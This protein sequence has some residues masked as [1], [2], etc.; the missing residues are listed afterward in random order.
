MHIFYSF[1]FVY[2]QAGEKENRSRKMK[3]EMMFLKLWKTKTKTLPAVVKREC[4]MAGAYFDLE[5]GVGLGDQ[6]QI[7]IK[8]KGKTKQTKTFSGVSFSSNKMRAK[9]KIDKISSLP[10]WKRMKILIW[11]SIKIPNKNHD[12]TK[13][14]R[15]AS[16]RLLLSECLIPI[17]HIQVSGGKSSA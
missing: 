4:Q 13:S 6:I 16:Q 10:R 7:Q 15:G 14:I 3:R 1:I 12:I 8:S 17:G 11:I 2:S 9:F 5:S